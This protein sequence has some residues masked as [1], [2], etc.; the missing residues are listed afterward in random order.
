VRSWIVEYRPHGGGPRCQQDGAI[1]LGSVSVTK[2]GD[3][4]G[5]VSRQGAV[6]RRCT[7]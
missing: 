5:D 2:R 6:R 4:A 7:A 3:A 1:T